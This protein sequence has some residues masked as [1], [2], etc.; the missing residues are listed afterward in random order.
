MTMA[1]K[2]DDALKAIKALETRMTALEA[3]VKNKK[4][5]KPEHE[6]AIKTALKQAAE[7]G[8]RAKESVTKAEIEGRFKM[9]EHQIAQVMGIAA[10]AASASKR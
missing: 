5:M 8:A 3:A 2:V 7:A 9:L 4:D 10:A 1:D 6:T